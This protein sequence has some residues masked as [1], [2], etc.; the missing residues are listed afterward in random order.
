MMVV[1]VVSEPVAGIRKSGEMNSGSSG[2]KDP[3][4]AIEWLGEKAKDI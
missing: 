2:P 4:S 3:V 1:S